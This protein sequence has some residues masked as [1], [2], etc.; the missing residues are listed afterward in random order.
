[1]LRPGIEFKRVE[2]VSHTLKVGKTAQFILCAISNNAKEN[3]CVA[4]ETKHEDLFKQNCEFTKTLN[5]KVSK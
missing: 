2:C 3:S 5:S 4:S 1:M